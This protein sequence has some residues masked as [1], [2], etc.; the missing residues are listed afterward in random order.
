VV[1]GLLVVVLVGVGVIYL[2]SGSRM[3]PVEGTAHALDHSQASVAEGQRLANAFGCTAC[4]GGNLGGNV[5]IDAMPFAM[6]PASNLT[7][8]RVGGEADDAQWELA[9]RHGIGFDRRPLFIMPSSS[10]SRL[11]DAHLSSIIAWARTLPAV[12]NPLPERQFGPIG[13]LAITLGQLP[14]VR[15]QIPDDVQHLQT[16][17]E[18][19][20]KFGYYLTRLCVD[21]H[22][23]DLRGGPPEQREPTPGP[24]LSPAGRLGSWDQSQFMTAIRTGRRPDRTMLNDS[25]MP[26][27]AIANLNDVELSAIWAYLSTMPAT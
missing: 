6:L 17:T 16:Q 26:W 5:L 9:V 12:E 18:A 14:P 23:D 25:T 4:H 7:S 11:S 21:C 19:T 13:R 8:G 15:S 1:A 2:I 22:G 10:Y 3:A 24:D 20:A 27:Q